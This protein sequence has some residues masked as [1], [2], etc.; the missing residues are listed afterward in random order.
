VKKRDLF[1]AD[2][3]DENNEDEDDADNAPSNDNKNQTYQNV[4]FYLKF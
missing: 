1:E 3:D 4:G 2:E